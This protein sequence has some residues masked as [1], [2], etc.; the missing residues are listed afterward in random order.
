MV[1]IAGFFKFCGILFRGMAFGVNQLCNPRGSIRQ[2]KSL[3]QVGQE[4]VTGNMIRNHTREAIRLCLQQGQRRSFP[5]RRKRENIHRAECFVH[6]ADTTRKD[7]RIRDAALLRNRGQAQQFPLFICSEQKKERIRADCQYFQHQP[8]Q[9]LLVF[10]RKQSAG[11]TNNKSVRWDFVILTHLSAMLLRKLIQTHI[12]SVPED[13]ASAFKDVFP[14]HPSPG[15]NTA[16]QQ[17]S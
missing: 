10:H 1:I 9:K 15:F 5:Q 17:M 4:Y 6:I 14:K 13:D 7:H 3:H 12:N 8:N 2:R 16:G 11:M